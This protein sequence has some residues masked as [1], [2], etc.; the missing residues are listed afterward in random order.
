MPLQHTIDA[1]NRTGVRTALE[2]SKEIQSQ[3]PGQGEADGWRTGLVNLAR[4]HAVQC[5]EILRLVDRISG[6]VI[7][8]DGLN[9]RPI[10]GVI[11]SDQRVDDR[12]AT[13][14]RRRLLS[15]GLLQFPRVG[16]RARAAFSRR[17]RIKWSRASSG[18]AITPPR[19][20]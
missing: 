11:R 1:A 6:V 20:S 17:S 19:E 14:I 7:A 9:R 18:I 2:A 4:H 13:L 10:V 5:R 12:L 3:N 16:R 8:K 15:Q